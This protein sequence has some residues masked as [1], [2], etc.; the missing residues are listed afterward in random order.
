MK[1]AFE[2]SIIAAILMGSFL[3]GVSQ[4]CQN[5][6]VQSKNNAPQSVGVTLSL[7][8]SPVD[9]INLT[10]ASAESHPYALPVGS[11]SPNPMT[12]SAHVSMGTLSADCSAS[13]SNDPVTGQCSNLT[14]PQFQMNISYKAGDPGTPGTPGTPATGTCKHDNG[15][16]WGEYRQLGMT[17]VPPHSGK[18][19]ATCEKG[20][21]CDCQDGT[22][23]TPA[24][25]PTPASISCEILFQP[26]FR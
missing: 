23:G 22:P 6:F 4:A 9:L 21:K 16:H 7:N 25:P 20:K 3:P 19:N 24:T 10:L 14:D 11:G 17:N 8:S 12:L 18:P 13:V 1:T 5:V 15:N 2:K 26:S